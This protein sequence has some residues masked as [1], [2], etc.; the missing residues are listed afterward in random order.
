MRMVPWSGKWLFQK[1]D[2]P[3][4]CSL[5]CFLQ[6]TRWRAGRELRPET[7]DSRLPAGAGSEGGC[8]VVQSS[9]GTEKQFRAPKE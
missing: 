5:L 3:G 1:W 8:E 7:L 6:G 9:E 4:L 2:G